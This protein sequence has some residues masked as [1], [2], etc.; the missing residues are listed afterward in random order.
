MKKQTSKK[1]QDGR[2]DDL[3]APLLVKSSYTFDDKEGLQATDPS[4]VIE[5][6]KD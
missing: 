6:A 4:D 3:A 1:A 5:E 2:E